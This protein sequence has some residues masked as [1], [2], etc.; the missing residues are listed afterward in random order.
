MKDT[1]LSTKKNSILLGVFHLAIQVNT[2]VILC[3]SL[4]VKKD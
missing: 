3:Y 4:D 2:S 1:G